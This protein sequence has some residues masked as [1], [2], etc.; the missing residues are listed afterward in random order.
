MMGTV[1]DDAAKLTKL[2][3]ALIEG[4]ESGPTEPF[5]FEAFIKRKL[6]VRTSDSSR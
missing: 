5:D 4:E 2:R 6:E 1:D 3:A